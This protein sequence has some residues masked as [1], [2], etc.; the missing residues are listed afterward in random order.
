ME[1][2]P[3]G[4]GIFHKLDE[5]VQHGFVEYAHQNVR[6]VRAVARADNAEHTAYVKAKVKTASE[7]ELEV[8][9]CVTYKV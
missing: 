1:P 5:Q 6:K 8:C 9:K 3:P 4:I 2:P 7:N